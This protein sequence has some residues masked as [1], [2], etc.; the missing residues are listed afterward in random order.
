MPLLT[1]VV[2][3]HFFWKFSCQLTS[4]S[5]GSEEDDKEDSIWEPQKKVSR[6]NRKQP[7][8]KEATNRKQRPRVKK[9]TPQMD[10]VSKDVAVKEE[11]VGGVAR[12]GEGYCIFQMGR[13]CKWQ[14]LQGSGIPCHSLRNTYLSSNCFLSYFHSRLGVEVLVWIMMSANICAYCEPGSMLS[15]SLRRSC[16]ILITIGN[17]C[18]NYPDFIDKK[19]EA[20]MLSDLLIEHS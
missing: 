11:L 6:N 10:D 4:R 18:G 12:C 3:F 2:W 16:L 7:A 14:K 19:S 20:K 17:G 1:F 9:N 8:S 5:S 13:Y 15:I